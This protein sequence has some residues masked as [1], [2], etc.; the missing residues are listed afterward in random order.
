MDHNNQIIYSEDD[1]DFSLYN[2]THVAK[3]IYQHYHKFIL[4]LLVFVIIYTVDYITHLNMIHGLTSGMP[5]VTA[6]ATDSK[7][8]LNK[9]K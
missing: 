6:A 3:Y 9:K 5:F 7:K 1:D 4:L 2:I 8:L